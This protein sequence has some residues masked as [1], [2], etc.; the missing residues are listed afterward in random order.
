MAIWSPY[1]GL[2]GG[3]VKFGVNPDFAS[4]TLEATLLRG[5]EQ[6]LLR[7][8]GNLEYGSVDFGVDPEFASVHP[9]CDTFVEK[10]STF[11]PQRR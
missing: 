3:S 5:I 4:V 1:Q 9:R 8:E 6:L 10:K 2:P 11:A 7:K